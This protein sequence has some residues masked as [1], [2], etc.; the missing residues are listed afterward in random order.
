M[1]AKGTKNWSTL[2]ASACSDGAGAIHA[3]VLMQKPPKK[4]RAAKTVRLE[5]LCGRGKNNLSGTGE[6]GNKTRNKRT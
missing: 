4:M 2:A 1:A 3:V 6:K 5:A